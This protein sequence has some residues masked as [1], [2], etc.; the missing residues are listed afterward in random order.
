MLIY[1]FTC[2]GNRTRIYP[3]GQLHASV[4]NSFFV[5]NI[6]TFKKFLYVTL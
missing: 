1:S 6:K 4:I 5:K 2:A 3:E